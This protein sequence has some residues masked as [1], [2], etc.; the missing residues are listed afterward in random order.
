M[1]KEREKERAMR[2]GREKGRSENLLSFAKLVMIEYIFH[3]G[4]EMTQNHGIMHISLHTEY[5]RPLTAAIICKFLA[6][7]SAST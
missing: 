5:R 6:K 7:T 3:D 4:L 1:K 2:K